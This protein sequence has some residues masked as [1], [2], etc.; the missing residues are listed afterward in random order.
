MHTKIFTCL[1]LATLLLTQCKKQDIRPSKAEK[2]QSLVQQAK[3]FVKEQAP[4]AAFDQL[5]W[6]Q[7]S[8]IKKEGQAVYLH[9]PVSN[10]LAAAGEAIYLKYNNVTF[11]GNYFSINKAPGGSWA[12]TTQSLNG[13]CTCE[14]MLTAEGR[15]QNC[16]V[17]MRGN[18]L[19]E[20]SNT[21]GARDAIRRVK[22]LLVNSAGQE[23][24]WASMLGI[25]QQGW[26]DPSM[27]NW[28]NLEYLS[29]DPSSINDPGRSNAP[30]IL[31]DYDYLD[32]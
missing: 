19:Y 29:S 28:T 16:R 24:I 2:E 1:T 20:L 14:A 30:Y 15:L 4:D 17:Y 7:T 10:Q 26:I 31:V 11:S 6:L 25:G 5:N 22:P 12:I 9:I 13:E 27:S 18:L 3:A 8:I 21:Q 32:A 23:L